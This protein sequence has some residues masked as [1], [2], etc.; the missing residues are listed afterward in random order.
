MREINR[1]R[2]VSRIENVSAQQ[3]EFFP[4]DSFNI[5]KKSDEYLYYQN[6][7][8]QLEGQL[9]KSKRNEYNHFVKNCSF[10]YRKFE[11]EDAENCMALYERWAAARREKYTDDVYKQMLEENRGVHELALRSSQV[12]GL[13]VRVVIIEGVIKAY[14][15]GYPLNK[16]VFCVL[17]E[18]ADLTVKGLPTFIFREFC[19]DPIVAKYKFINVMDDFGTPNLQKN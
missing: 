9:F 12:L 7:I 1:G 4:K 5:S 10:K 18:V 3:L 16:D 8:V 11:A 15:A 17:L 13:E 14:T 6:D 2:G 19:H